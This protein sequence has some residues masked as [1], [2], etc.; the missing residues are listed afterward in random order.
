MSLD[1]LIECLELEWRAHE[2]SGLAEE[3]GRDV[4]WRLLKVA[5]DY[6]DRLKYAPSAFQTAPISTV[7]ICL[8]APK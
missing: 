3:A 5:E 2:P 1:L 7:L 6:R 4:V 8:A